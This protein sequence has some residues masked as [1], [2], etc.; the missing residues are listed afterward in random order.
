MTNMKHT[1]LLY[2]LYAWVLISSGFTLIAKWTNMN[3]I[4]EVL[5]KL[6]AISAIIWV[7]LD[8]LKIQY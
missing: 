2:V 7:I 3:K 4:I 5:V 8:F 6:F 1:I